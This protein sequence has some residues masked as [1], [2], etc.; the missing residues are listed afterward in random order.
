MTANANNHAQ[1]HFHNHNASLGRIP[2]G[3]MPNRHSRELSSDANLAA[4]RDQTRAFPSIQSALQASAAPFG[5]G[6]PA[7]VNPHSS[8]GS[9]TPGS[10]ASAPISNYGSFYGGGSTYNSPTATAVPTTGAYGVP[11]LAMGMHNLSV[12]GGSMYSPQNY[13]GYGALY[14]P[15][16]QQQQQ[17]QHQRDSQQRVIAHRRQLDNE[18]MA[19][20]RP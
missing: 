9:A 13:T 15:A 3:A 19:P 10:T 4:V 7:Q 5:P 2:A 20:E 12:N 16:Q 14:N 11:L 17:Q 8:A 1:Q 18:G 6:I